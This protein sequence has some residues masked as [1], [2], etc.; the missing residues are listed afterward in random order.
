M[1]ITDIPMVRG[2]V[3]LVAVV[4]VFSGGSAHRVSITTEADSRIEALEEALARRGKPDIFN[5]DQG[6]QFTSVDF[7]GVR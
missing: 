3:D 6:S 7:T 5:S 1:D 2:F 4:D